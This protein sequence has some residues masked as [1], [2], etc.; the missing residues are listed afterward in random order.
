MI[1]A[2]RNASGTRKEELEKKKQIEVDLSQKKYYHASDANLI[3][4]DEN[5]SGGVEILSMFLYY[6]MMSSK[7]SIVKYNNPDTNLVSRQCQALNVFS[8]ASPC[9]AREDDNDR[10]VRGTII[11]QPVQS[12]FPSIIQ[13]QNL[14]ITENTTCKFQINSVVLEDHV[15]CWILLPNRKLAFKTSVCQEFSYWLVL[16]LVTRSQRGK[17]NY[18]KDL[19]KERKRDI[20]NP[21]QLLLNTPGFVFT[22]YSNCAACP[23]HR[24]LRELQ[25]L[26]ISKEYGEWKTIEEK[27]PPV[28][29]TEIRTSIS[30]SSAVGLNTTSA[31]ANCATEAGLNARR[32]L[33]QHRHA[34][35]R[36]ASL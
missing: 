34:L 20:M 16:T 13:T 24:N 35:K 11:F 10:S 31:L 29:P 1:H 2:V 19:C 22:D 4:M 7:T 5:F 28:H 30:P 23:A 27:P 33:V 32:T 21:L 12:Y 26:E 9:Q 17:G 14:T 25:C 8:L 6:S 36:T 15:K 18:D 3:G